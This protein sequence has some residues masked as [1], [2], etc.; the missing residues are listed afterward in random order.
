M[1]RSF[2]NILLLFCQ[3]RQSFILLLLALL[4]VG[5]FGLQIH[6]ILLKSFGSYRLLLLVLLSVFGELISKVHLL[7][8]I[9]N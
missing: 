2:F 8:T 7:L 1:R 6:F 5:L 3:N 4:K 9:L